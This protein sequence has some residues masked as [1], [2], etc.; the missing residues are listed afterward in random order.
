MLV[1]LAL[2]SGEKSSICTDFGFYFHMLLELVL[3]AGE[4]SLLSGTQHNCKAA[5]SIV[6][7]AASMP[8]LELQKW[9]LN[10]ARTC[11]ASQNQSF[12]SF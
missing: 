12:F 5:L 2:I 7:I 1:E 9:D 6:V 10:T 3:I 4:K 11:I 8:F